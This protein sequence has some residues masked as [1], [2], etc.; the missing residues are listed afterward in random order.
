MSVQQPKSNYVANARSHRVPRF[1]DGAWINVRIRTITCTMRA[2]C[3][4]APGHMPSIHHRCISAGRIAKLLTSARSLLACVCSLK[5]KQK[6]ER[7]RLRYLKSV[8][9]SSHVRWVSGTKSRGAYITGPLRFAHAGS[10]YSVLHWSTIY[11]SVDLDLRAGFC[12]AGLSRLC[13]ELEIRLDHVQCAVTSCYIY[14]KHCIAYQNSVVW[15]RTFEVPKGI[16]K[17]HLFC[18]ETLRL[19]AR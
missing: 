15:D 12:S 1:S 7:S 19:W 18:M 13:A 17:F 14:N 9:T 16:P 8:R 11:I 5:G 10:H 2:L 4:Y 3:A 6:N